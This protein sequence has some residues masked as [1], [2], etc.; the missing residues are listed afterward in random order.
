MKLHRL[1]ADGIAQFASY[2]T[3]LKAEPTLPPP[4]HLLTEAGA[5][6]PIGADVEVE[7]KAFATRFDA[8]AYLDIKLTASGLP[9]P[10]RDAGLWAWLALF[11]FDQLCPTGKA[12]ARKVGEQARYIPQINVPRRFY[13]HMLAGPLVMYRAHA[14]DPKRLLALLSNPMDVATSETY[15][16]FIENTSLIAC[17]AVV[18]VATWLYYD[19]ARCKLKR[20]AG[21]K[22]AGGCRRLIEY[23]Q[24][25]DCTFDLPILTKERLA[26]MLPKEFSRFVPQQMELVN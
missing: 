23:L 16:L 26:G 17:K 10:E 3:Q 12:G 7:D 14:D 11:Y 19:R 18:E 8:A 15:R 24:Q 25:I 5:S 21:S 4:A 9:S 20:G 6:E 13:R 2:L 22:D 1:T